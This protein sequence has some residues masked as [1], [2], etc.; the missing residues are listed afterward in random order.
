VYHAGDTNVFTDM[1]IINELYKPTH[2]LIP[3]GNNFTMGPEE[4]GY[5]VAKFLTNANTVIPM[6]YGTIPIL[7]GTLEEFITHYHK[8]AVEYNR[9]QI[10]I[11]DP[12][13]LS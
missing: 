11:I 5:A 13:T 9:K 10:N 6:H 7:T 1:E 8:F 4:A 12:H 3:I 2:L